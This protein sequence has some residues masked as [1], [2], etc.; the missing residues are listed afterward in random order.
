MKALPASSAQEF[1]AKIVVE[2]RYGDFMLADPGEGGAYDEALAILADY[3]HPDA[4]LIKLGRQFEAAKDA[5]RP[6]ELELRRASAILQ[7]ACKEAGIPDDYTGIEARKP[8]ARRTGYEKAY[9]AF[10]KAHGK[11]IKLMRAIHRAKASTLEGYAVKVAAIAFDQSDFEISDPV[12]SDV[13]E[14]ELYRTARN[15]AKTVQAKATLPPPPK[16]K[17]LIDAYE[18]ARE[19]YENAAPENEGGPEWDAYEAAEHAVIIYPCR[20]LEDVRMKARFFLENSGL[21]DTIRN[22]RTS[23]EP[24]E[25]ALMP[26]LRSLLG[27]VAL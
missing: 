11:T 24:E 12:P 16:L 20:S 6:L 22:S 7:K 27:E 15:M 14:R 4:K 17:A 10:T 1:A 8:I 13:A 19:D 25:E 18:K 26:F 21:Y 5:A 2:S 9:S 23:A 3:E